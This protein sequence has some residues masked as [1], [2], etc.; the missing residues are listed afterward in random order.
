LFAGPVAARIVGLKPC[1]AHLSK[2]AWNP[3]A[4]VPWTPAKAGP[5][6]FA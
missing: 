2:K 1:A 4:S 5:G 6:R 3:A